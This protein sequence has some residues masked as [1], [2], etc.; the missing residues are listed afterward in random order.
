MLSDRQCL[1][2]VGAKCFGAGSQIDRQLADPD[3]ERD[4][5]QRDDADRNLLR[6]R[7]GRPRFAEV[8]AVAD[9]P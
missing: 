8:L 4:F 5:E 9:S 3:L 1:E 6:V 2:P 7:N